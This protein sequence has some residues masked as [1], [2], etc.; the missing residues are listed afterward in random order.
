M[1]MVRNLRSGDL[2]YRRR[3]GRGWVAVGQVIKSKIHGLFCTS[4]SPHSYR[5][6]CHVCGRRR[7]VRRTGFWTL[8]RPGIRRICGSRWAG[9]LA[10]FLFTKPD[11]VI[12]GVSKAGTTSL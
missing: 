2:C 3:A 11:F 4:G 7:H 12:I 1:V 8:P 10:S 5:V 9:R 6:V